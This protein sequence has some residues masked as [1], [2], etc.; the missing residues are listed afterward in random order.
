MSSL[1]RPSGRRRD[2]GSKQPKRHG[3]CGVHAKSEPL[4]LEPSFTAVGAV[5]PSNAYKCFHLHIYIYIYTHPSMMTWVM[6]MGD[7]SI[8]VWMVMKPL[9]RCRG[10]WFQPVD[11]GCAG[12]NPAGRS[13][14]ADRRP[15]HARKH[16]HEPV[17]AGFWCERISWM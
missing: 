12:W 7:K 9:A 3:K 6:F 2:Y 15:W 11:H 5:L 4:S 17:G 1:Q 13:H 14:E 16:P 8:P 10:G